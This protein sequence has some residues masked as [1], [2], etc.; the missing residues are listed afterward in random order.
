MTKEIFEERVERN[1][2]RIF[3]TWTVGLCVVIALI[4]FLT[5]N[6]MDSNF[7]SRADQWWENKQ[8][9]EDTDSPA[10]DWAMCLD[11]CNPNDWN[12]TTCF[13]QCSTK[14]KTANAEP[15]LKNYHEVCECVEN[16]MIERVQLARE[17]CEET[18]VCYGDCDLHSYFC[19]NTAT[20]DL[21]SCS[22]ED[23]DKCYQLIRYTYKT[24]INASIND[25]CK[26]LYNKTE[27]RV[28]NETSCTLGKRKCMFVRWE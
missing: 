12:D 28:W 24:C 1:E 27:V 22:I 20:I 7:D 11:K 10:L 8:A 9:N 23:Y 19:Y 16:T 13:E 26:Q 18:G 25:F 3:M 4:A 17:W 2:N 14:L 6:I 15:N 21:A 5:W